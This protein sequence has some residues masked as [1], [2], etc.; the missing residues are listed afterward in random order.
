M[1]RLAAV[2]A[3]TLSLS[4]AGPAFA[5]PDPRAKITLSTSCADPASSTYTVAAKLTGTRG[6]V[7]AK[8]TLSFPA[9]ASLPTTQVLEHVQTDAVYVG[10]WVVWKS[11]RGSVRKY[12]RVQI[13]FP[14]C[15]TNMVHGSAVS[16]VV[17]TVDRRTKRVPR[18]H[19]TAN[20]HK[21]WTKRHKGQVRGEGVRR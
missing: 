10:A 21:E 1:K 12:V 18:A 20:R 3:L 5:Q 11:A 6:A 7:V 15:A 17:Q 2:L 4:W 16:E 14:D 19:R 8:P 9:G 13:A